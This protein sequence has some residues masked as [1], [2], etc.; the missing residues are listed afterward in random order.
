MKIYCVLIPFL[1]GLGAEEH[2]VPLEE[3]QKCKTRFRSAQDVEHPIMYLSDPTKAGYAEN[4]PCVRKVYGI[5][6]YDITPEAE[7]VLSQF[8]GVSNAGEILRNGCQRAL[9]QLRKLGLRGL[10]P[11]KCKSPADDSL[12]VMK[13]VLT[14][15]LPD[16]KMKELPLD[17]AVVSKILTMPNEYMLRFILGPVK[18]T[19]LLLEQG[20]MTL[21]DSQYA[22]IVVTMSKSLDEQFENPLLE[23]RARAMHLGGQT[24]LKNNILARPRFKHD[25]VFMVGPERAEAEIKAGIE[26]FKVQ[27][28][29]RVL[30][31]TSTN[32]KLVYEKLI[33]RMSDFG[34]SIESPVDVCL[35]NKDL[36][37]AVFGEKQALD[38]LARR[39]QEAFG[40]LNQQAAKKDYSNPSHAVRPAAAVTKSNPPER[41]LRDVG[42][43]I[44]DSVL[45]WMKDYA[46]PMKMFS[47][48]Q[49]YQA[50]ENT[51]KSVVLSKQSNKQIVTFAEA[52]ARQLPHIEKVFKPSSTSVSYLDNE[53]IIWF[54]VGPAPGS[55]LW[56]YGPNEKPEA[57]KGQ[58]GRTVFERLFP[59]EHVV[60]AAAKKAI[61]EAVENQS[62][63]L[64]QLKS[65]TITN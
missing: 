6:E 32:K 63:R 11:S 18:A 12:R 30:G 62:L 35:P 22:Q 17:D 33:K 2:P 10:L 25:L 45:E 43:K 36:L 15:H 48:K 1:N 47:R 5:T 38:L 37:I 19:R 16:S 58:D 64:E 23:L 14:E 41:D 4:L 21:I 9:N 49:K 51:G 59:E 61:A 57:E 34:S 53:T 42:S 54:L 31:K 39:A 55:P 3:V 46:V 52:F 24:T 26:N 29:Q 65:K 8:V 56:K 44:K 20:I 50:N 28:F 40:R 7:A 60:K 27:L 13:N